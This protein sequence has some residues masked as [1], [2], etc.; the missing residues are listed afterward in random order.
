MCK[1]NTKHAKVNGWIK[2]PGK[3]KFKTRRSTQKIPNYWSLE[4]FPWSLKLQAIESH[5]YNET[6]RPEQ[7]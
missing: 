4:V 5:L 1:V 7:N 6:M 3:T 2:T